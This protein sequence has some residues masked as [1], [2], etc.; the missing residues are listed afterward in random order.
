VVLETRTL[1][2]EGRYDPDF[3]SLLRPDTRP[4]VLRKISRT[5]KLPVAPLARELAD[6]R[7]FL[8]GSVTR[9]T[10]RD[11]AFQSSG[12][13]SAEVKDALL[14]AVK[15]NIVLSGAGIGF[16]GDTTP[17]VKGAFASFPADP[18][19]EPILTLLDYNEKNWS[20]PERL[21]FLASVLPVAFERSDKG[22][23]SG[24]TFYQDAE[25]STIFFWLYR[26]DDH[27][28]YFCEWPHGLDMSE[29]LALPKG[30]IHLLLA[31][32]IEREEMYYAVQG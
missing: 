22:R 1:S 21:R 7:E 6:Y 12:Q 16:G 8:R 4:A 30:I 13:L 17:P 3:V 31:R 11:N 27:K 5:L 15:K 23:M 14:A 28:Y 2:T 24:V 18:G 20:R 10:A 19:R 29:A 25:T 32:G 9:T 26:Q